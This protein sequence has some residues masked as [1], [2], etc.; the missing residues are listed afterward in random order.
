MQDLHSV[1]AK[2]FVVV[3]LGLIG[4]TPH[5]ITTRGKNGSCAEDENIDA[6]MF[7][8]KLRDLVVQNN[9]LYHDSKYI[10]INSTAGT[11]DNSLGKHFNYYYFIR[12]KY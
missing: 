2:K 3:G 9:N 6:L 5:A 7:S 12:G 4:C 8:H 10:F 11:V 1:G